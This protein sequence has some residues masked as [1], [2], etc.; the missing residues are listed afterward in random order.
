MNDHS[1][2]I[3]APLARWSSRIALFSASL[4]L[5]GV[6]LHRLF[7]LPTPVAL[8]LFAVGLGGAA[9]ALLAG[10]IAAIRIWRKGYRG[11]GSAAVGILL[12]LIV[13]GWPVA[14]VAAYSHLPRISDVTTDINAPPRFVAVVARREKG[15]NAP[16][17]PGAA[18]AGEQLKAYPDLRTFLLDRPAEE[19]FELVE[20]AVRRLKWKVVASEA[21]S[22][23]PLK[24]G[25]IEATDQTLLIGFTDDIA[26]RV[27]GNVTR[28]RVDIRSASRY[29]NFDLG[30]NAARVRKFLT[31]LQA[32][33]D[34]TAPNAVAG[35][36]GLR[37]T[38]VGAMV[39]K[40]KGR[41]QPKAEVRTGRDR[42]PAGAQRGRAPRE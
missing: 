12:S 23:R 20:E 19:A 18:A 6:A 9:I 32:R 24:A 8:N 33:V 16:A 35:R 30:Q 15:M 36:R 41:D 2:D 21:A 11:A 26:I 4:L 22:A 42:V 7:S 17:Y 3:V 25:V 38:R 31:E 10:L 34:A 14:Y 1:N 5:I 39:K 40:G 27:E 29:G 13:I 37:T 28:S